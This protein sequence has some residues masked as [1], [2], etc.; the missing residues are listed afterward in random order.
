MIIDI[1]CLGTVAMGFW[2]G[3]NR[4]IVQTAFSIIALFVGLL[5]AFKFSEVTNSL[6]E[7]LFGNDNPLIYFLKALRNCSRP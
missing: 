3:Y 6:L 5:V 1:L 4:G 2:M 7:K